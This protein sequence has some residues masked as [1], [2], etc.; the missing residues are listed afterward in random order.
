[1]KIRAILF[2]QDGTLY[3]FSVSQHAEWWRLTLTFVS[4]HIT[5]ATAA[6]QWIVTNKA[7]HKSLGAALHSHGLL[8]AYER[9]VFMSPSMDPFSYHSRD[10]KLAKL[11][12]TLHDRSI[13]LAVVTSS[14]NSVSRFV[15]RTLGALGIA[16]LFDA[17]VT[18][19]DVSELKPSRVHFQ[20]ALSQLGV[21]P[22]D[23][24]VVGDEIEKDLS[25][26][27]ALG[28]RAFLVLDNGRR[29]PSER[30]ASA[31]NAGAGITPIGSVRELPS[32]I[33]A[34]EQ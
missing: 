30:Y 25:P 8:E 14:P 19:S 13:R 10:C 26:A 12:M 9:E 21:A 3:P 34:I 24:A 32:I 28:M 7:T 20:A 17:I 31:N 29:S 18:A 23:A 22:T 6:E 33:D 15:D 16:G 11:L 27:R 1:M 5:H 2:D 4:R